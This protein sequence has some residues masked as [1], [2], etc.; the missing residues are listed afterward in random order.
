MSKL[1]FT[2]GTEGE[3]ALVA[4]T[5]KTVLYAKS[6]ATHQTAVF[7][8][9]VS[10]DGAVS[11]NEP[12]IIKLVRITTDGT[13]TS[14]TA[15]LLNDQDITPQ[16]SGGKNAT[17]EPTLTTI[18]KTIEVHP[19]SGYEEHR[20]FDRPYLIGPGDRLGLAITAPDNVN[21]VAWLDCEE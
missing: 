17:V 18:I 21:C 12:I 5:E 1:N 7:G 8:V 16:A 3:V 9:H 13:V 19:Q 2:I 6:G 11:G 10:F 15:R 20:P 14:V 4:A